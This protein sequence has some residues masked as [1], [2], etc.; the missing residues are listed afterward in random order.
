M[1]IAQKLR[2][3][4]EEALR[5]MAIVEIGKLLNSTLDLDALL[6]VILDTAVKNLKA[7]RGTVYMIDHEKQELWSLVQR[8][9][10]KFRLP[11]GQG[12]AGDVAQS[13]KSVILDDAYQD[14][15]RQSRYRLS[16]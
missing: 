2:Q 1:D 16:S 4:T 5:L 12:I 10:E 14:P 15:P 11:I 6:E 3:V 7:E 8:G 13:G 9:K